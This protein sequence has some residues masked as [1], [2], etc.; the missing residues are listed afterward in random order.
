MTWYVLPQTGPRYYN[1]PLFVEPPG[2]P[3]ESF[4]FWILFSEVE[5]LDCLMER[6]AMLPTLR[7]GRERSHSSSVCSSLLERSYCI[8]WH[9]AFKL[10]TALY[11]DN[12]FGFWPTQVS[13]LM[14][15]EAFW[16]LP[17]WW[18]WLGEPTTL[19]N[20]HSWSSNVLSGTSYQ[21]SVSFFYSN[22]YCRECCYPYLLLHLLRRR[23]IS[24]QTL[25]L[26]IFVRTA[27]SSQW[28]MIIFLSPLD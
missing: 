1:L 17:T 6:W 21:L 26:H 5:W 18:W 19:F 24:R 25:N 2:Q 3:P 4:S 20:I 7:R 23:R 10:R 16:R 12:C 11:P 14:A 15:L 22:D 13:R 9:V 8:L 28:K 27:I